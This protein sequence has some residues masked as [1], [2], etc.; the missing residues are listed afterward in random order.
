[1]VFGKLSGWNE[2]SMRM[3]HTCPALWARDVNP[4]TLAPAA[5]T[6]HYLQG[7]EDQLGAEKHFLSKKYN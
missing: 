5:L 4:K 1:M 3:V 2:Q 7:R 6:V